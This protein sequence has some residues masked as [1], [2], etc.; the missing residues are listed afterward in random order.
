LAGRD[1]QPHVAII[2]SQLAG[3]GDAGG[4]RGYDDDKISDPSAICWPKPMG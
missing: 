2:D 4:E 1:P 3:T